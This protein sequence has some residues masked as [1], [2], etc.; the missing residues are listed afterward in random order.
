[1]LI[2]LDVGRLL[3][4]EV[5]G[6]ARLEHVVRAALLLAIAANYHEDNLGIMVFSDEIHHYVTPQ[7]GRRGLQQVLEVLAVV[8][9]KMVESDYPAAI[10]HL[11]V[12]HR[13]RGLTVLFTDVVDRLASGPLVTHVGSLRTRHVPL[14]VTLRNA[15]LDAL[16]ASR[17]ATT[18]DAYRKAAAEELLSAREG[19]ISQ[20]RRRGALIVDVPARDAARAVVDRYLSLKRGGRL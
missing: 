19:A 9:P 4:E 2:L 16:A 8:R 17:P 1:M 20:L 7:R 10:R 6:E 3:T 15:D 13:K 5:E 14:V 12:R 18:S 11:A